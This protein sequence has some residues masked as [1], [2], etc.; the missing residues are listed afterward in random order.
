MSGSDRSDERV[1]IRDGTVT[2][3]ARWWTP[4]THAL[5]RHLRSKG[6][7]DVPVP[8]EI[9]GDRETLTWIDGLS[10]AD[11]WKMIVP[12]QGL[13]AFARFLRRYHEATTGFVL[14]PDGQWAFES[15][16]ARPD[17]VI[18]HGDYGPWNVVWRQ[19]EPVGLVD[20]D[21]AGPGDRL[22]DVAYAVEFAAPFCDDEE[23]IQWRSYPT[24]PERRRRCEVFAEAYGFDSTQGLVDAVIARQELDIQRVL[25][26]AGKGVEPQR[27]WVEDGTV[28]EFRARIDWSRDHAKELGG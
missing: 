22:L 27:S 24:P 17:E 16:P 25:M 12:E 23:A 8:I 1:V 2:R 3:P 21:F 14:P 20:F 28:N 7:V 18:C 13:R 11:A 19:G 4:T 10:G 6:F 9:T 26:L 15:R 5:L